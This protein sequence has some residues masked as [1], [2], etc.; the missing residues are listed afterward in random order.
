[1]QG[2]R[3]WDDGEQERRRM[4]QRR[5]IRRRRRRIRMIQR[6]VVLCIAVLVIGF[7]IKG[8]ISSRQAN[9]DNP[10]G[11][12]DGDPE[13]MGMVKDPEGQKDDIPKEKVKIKNAPEEVVIVLDPGHG[14]K[15]P[16]TLWKNIYEKDI[17][18]A[19]IQ[20]L[21]QILKEE[22]YQVALT[23]SED[24]ARTL[25][26]RVKVGADKEADVFVSVHQNALEKDTVTSGIETYC[27][28]N[29]NKKSGILAD[30]IHSRLIDSTGAKDKKVKKDSDLFVII[31]SE[32]PACLVETG[33]ITSTK[34][35]A[36]LLDDSY[37]DKLAQAIAEGIKE[38]VQEHV[39]AKGGAA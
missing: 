22:G 26:E 1:M 20:K 12:T 36:K 24:V 33:F 19:I 15:D 34:E 28:Q 7:G 37:Q 25:K 21:E 31:N 17:N 23:R 9:E 30:A 27:N 39:L 8:I 3:T 4:E 14:G 11:I 38:F 16:G 32:M 18:L 6:G 29:S 13:P 10:T 5:A 2:R 35:R